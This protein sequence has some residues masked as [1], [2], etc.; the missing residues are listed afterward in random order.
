MAIE[1]WNDDRLESEFKQVDEQ[2]KSYTRDLRTNSEAINFISSRVNMLEGKVEALKTERTEAINN[3]FQ[4]FVIFAT[5][6]AS[7]LTAL[8][9]FL[10]QRR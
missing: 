9:V 7:P 4:W 10:L 3:K 5:L 2:F 6:L 1:N 8:V